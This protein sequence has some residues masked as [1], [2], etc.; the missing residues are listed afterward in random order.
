MKIT[1]GYRRFIF[2]PPASHASFYTRESTLQ[3]LSPSTARR[4]QV[5]GG[6]RLLKVG[7]SRPERLEGM[8]L[9]SKPVFF[10]LQQD[11]GIVWRLFLT[12]SRHAGRCSEL[13]VWQ[14]ARLP[15]LESNA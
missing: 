6:R 13:G 3:N 2:S 1:I 7:L 9:M 11:S 4:C 14:A 10:I 12:M 8:K 15:A 5:S